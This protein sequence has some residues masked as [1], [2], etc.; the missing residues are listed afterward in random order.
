MKRSLM[1][2]LRC[3]DGNSTIEFVMFVPV[4]MILFLSSF[5]LGMVMTRNVMLDHGLDV[6]VRDIRLGTLTVEEGESYYQALR[7]SI[8]EN[9]SIIPDCADNLKLEMQVVSPRAFAG[10]A[11]G[12]DC[13]NRDDPSAPVREFTGGGGNNLMLLRACALFDPFFPT[14]GLGAQLR[15]QQAGGAYALVSTSS[16]V[17]E[18]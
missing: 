12:A 1:H 6:S 8:C 14:S 18:P 7:R 16:F 2:F 13:V 9:A 10:L 3:E 11:A 5:E 17:V 4:F 15:D